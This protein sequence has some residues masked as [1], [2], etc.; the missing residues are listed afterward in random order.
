M[1][2][3]GANV[4]DKGADAISTKS[5]RYTPQN[6]ADLGTNSEFCS[7]H[8]PGQWIS[9]DFKALRIEPTPYTIQTYYVGRHAD[10]LKSCTVE[11]S[12]D[13]AVDGT[14]P[15]QKRREPQRQARREDVCGRVV[16]VLSQD[17]PA[18]SLPESRW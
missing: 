2:T 6:A 18:P 12:D 5:F 3:C 14:R 16:P 10:H 9:W 17:P 8:E 1:L 4:H 15:A 13:G 11:G 7:K